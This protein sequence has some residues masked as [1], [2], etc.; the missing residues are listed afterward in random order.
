METSDR[1]LSY[2]FSSCLAGKLSFQVL[3]K[4]CPWLWVKAYLARGLLQ[5]EIEVNKYL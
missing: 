1:S 3:F 4:E 2:H 5:I